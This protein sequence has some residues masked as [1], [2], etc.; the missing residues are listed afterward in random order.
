VGGEVNHTLTVLETAPHTH[1]ALARNAN[2]DTAS[3]AS[4]AFGKLPGTTTYATALTGLVT[5]APT[6][7]AAAGGS[8]PHPNESPYLVVNLIIAL[9]GIF[10]S[11]S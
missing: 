8:Q 4:H 5:M 10:P 11:R 2:G 6:A 1:Q 3:V 7:V 9:Q